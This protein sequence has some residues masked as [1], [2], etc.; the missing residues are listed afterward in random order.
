MLCFPI[1]SLVPYLLLSLL[2]PP[3]SPHRLLLHPPSVV[4]LEAA[5]S[6]LLDYR[7]P[8]PTSLLPAMW[9]HPRFTTF[10]TVRRLAAV[11]RRGS[12]GAAHVTRTLQKPGPVAVLQP[13]LQNPCSASIPISISFQPPSFPSRRIPPPPPCQPKPPC[14]RFFNL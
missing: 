1:L 8:H 10:Y 9:S 6:N 2:S 13:T 14:P 5:S 12:N 3:R 11:Q 7:T 4:N